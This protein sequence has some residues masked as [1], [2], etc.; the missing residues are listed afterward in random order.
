MSAAMP[1]PGSISSADVQLTSTMAAVDATPRGEDTPMRI[2]L[3][4]DFSGRGGQRAPGLADRKPMRI[5]RDNFEDVLAK[6]SVMLTL[7]GSK[8]MPWTFRFRELDDFQPDR[9]FQQVQGFEALRELRADLRNPKKF[10][11]AAEEMRGWSAAK[12]AAP[13]EALAEPSEPARVLSRA[14]QGDILDQILAE[15]QAPP[16][17]AVSF[18]GGDWQA[19][20]QKIVVPHLLPKIDY[21]EQAE[22]EAVVNEAAAAPMR[23]LLHHPDFQAVESAW[24]AAHFLTRRLE[25]DAHLQL[26]LLDI[27]KAEL[28]ADLTASDDLSKTQMCRLLVKQPV[29]DPPWGVV[30]GLYTFDDSRADMDLLARLALLAQGAG[31]PFLAEAS[32]RL[33][34]CSSLAQTPDPEDWKPLD[35]EAQQRWERLRGRPEAA[36]LGLALPRFLLRLPYGKDTTPV[37]EFDF[38]ENPAG[39]DHE[40]YLWGNPA[41]ACAYL[42][43]ESFLRRGWNGDAGCVREIADLPLHVYQ[44]DGE[45]RIKPCAEVLLG[46]EA[47][48]AI[49]DKG[50]MPLLSVRDRDTV[51][52]PRF[53]SLAEPATALAG[54]WT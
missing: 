54:Q 52:V 10:A 20:L 4:G 13:A 12:P 39:A 50:L 14:E 18:P 17:K 31:A 51:R 43:A 29:G 49:L 35:A 44:D 48:E 19:Y 46:D 9:L 42:L 30:A 1:K 11:K 23:A 2:V 3:L 34:G 27:T 24:R 53:Q 47:M 21:A 41:V 6:L 28:A 26:Y 16:Q 33:V 40:G 32:C 36:Y 7:S 8:D 22:L 25:T 5:D 38:E 37:E 15:T 45:S